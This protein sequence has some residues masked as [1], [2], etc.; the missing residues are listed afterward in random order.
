MTAAWTSGSRPKAFLVHF[1][2]VSLGLVATNCCSLGRNF[3]LW[4]QCGQQ[5]GRRFAFHVGPRSLI[6]S[7]DDSCI[8]NLSK[9]QT[10]KQQAKSLTDQIITATKQLRHQAETSKTY[11]A[12]GPLL[13]ILVFSKQILLLFFSPIKL[14]AKPLPQVC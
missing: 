6:S 5:N 10:L 13:K 2:T 8:F 12:Q 4:D 11:T 3:P 9:S 7:G 14:P 1:S